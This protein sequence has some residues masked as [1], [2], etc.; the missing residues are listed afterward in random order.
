LVS[1]F[2][3]FKKYWPEYNGTIYLNT[4]T[5]QFTHEGLNIVSKK[6]NL[7]TVQNRITWNECLIR[8]I[9]VI[10]VRWKKEVVFL[11]EFHNI[12]ID[13]AKR[14]FFEVKK[15]SI[16]MRILSKI[17]RLPVEIISYYGLIQLKS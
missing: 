7:N 5:K 16:Y 6:N 8:A 9:N 2:A 1:I 12:K 17:K 14:G 13:Y 4:E 15:P 10:G 11:F 3:L